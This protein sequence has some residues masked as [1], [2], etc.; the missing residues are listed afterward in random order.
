VNGERSVPALSPTRVAR[1]ALLL[2]TLSLSAEAQAAFSQ[3]TCTTTGWSRFPVAIGAWEFDTDP[4]AN[5]LDNV[6]SSWPLITNSN[7]LYMGP[8][9]APRFVT[10]ANLD[11]LEARH[12]GFPFNPGPTRYTGSVNSSLSQSLELPNLW[13]PE[14]I[15]VTGVGFYGET[16]LTWHTDG[17]NAF[18]PP[19]FDGLRVRCATD[20][21]ASAVSALKILPNKRYDGVLIASKDSMYF[22]VSQDA[23]VPMVITLNNYV[24]GTDFDLYASTTT[25][26]PDSTNFTWRAASTRGEE[27]L[28]LPPPSAK[29]TIYIGVLSFTGAGNYGLHAYQ[30]AHLNR[31]QAPKICALYDMTSDDKRHLAEALRRASAQLLG[32]TN[33]NYFIKDFNVI[34]GDDALG[35]HVLHS[36]IL[37]PE[38]CGVLAWPMAARSETTVNSLGIYYCS[39]INL[40]KDG[41]SYSGATLAHEYGHACLGLPDEYPEGTVNQFYCPHS[42]MGIT[43]HHTFCMGRD[44]CLDGNVSC[45]DWGPPWP[46]AWERLE[47]YDVIHY[48]ENFH[49]SGNATDPTPLTENETLKKTVIK[50]KIDGVEFNQ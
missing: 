21:T 38:H 22:R 24:N 20:Q 29:R 15:G 17:S 1:V 26:T 43:S 39:T 13:A 7:V 10:E 4:T 33:G 23:N 45:P 11:Y 6:H 8:T 2:G 34:T 32:A 27:A 28:Y 37:D 46:S 41:L 49:V 25:A 31:A 35:E 16:T 48:G 30:V 19:L 12:A 14:V 3:A 5:Y 50:V 18:R 42:M 9:A 36:N 47:L 44:H 40:F